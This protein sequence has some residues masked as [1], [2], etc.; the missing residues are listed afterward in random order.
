MSK[1]TLASTSM[2]TAAMV[3]TSAMR[4]MNENG[5]VTT[6]TATPAAAQTPRPHYAAVVPLKWL[7]PL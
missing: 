4:K 5:M 7:S 2:T 6:V 3:S 1:S